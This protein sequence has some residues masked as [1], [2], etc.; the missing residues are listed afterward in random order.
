M[1]RIKFLMFIGIT[2]IF[3]GCPARSLSPLFAEKDLL[4]N[5]ALVGTWSDEA[6]K[7]HFTFEQSDDKGYHLT[8][9]EEDGD[10]TQYK[11]GLGKIGKYWF[12]DSYPDWSVND[13]HYLG[14]HMISRIWIDGD[15]LRMS[16]LEG[17]RLK[18]MIGNGTLKIAHAIVDNE[19]VLTAP[20]KELQKLVLRLADDKDAFSPPKGAM[21]RLSH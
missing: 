16:S 3:I 9:R 20:T 6:K 11:V 14:T 5:P 4:F 17:D 18:K 13:Y 15:T 7:D 8:V 19:V 12:M 1:K 2:N 10:T 21:I